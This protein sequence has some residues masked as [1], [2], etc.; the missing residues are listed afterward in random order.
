MVQVRKGEVLEPVRRA[1]SAVLIIFI[2]GAFFIIAA[3]LLT[4]GNLVGRLEAKGQ[5]LRI[6]DK[7][8]RR[9]SYLASS[10][11]LA[12]GF[13][14][15]IR[16]ILSNIQV[17]VQWLVSRNAADK[18]PELKEPLYQIAGEVARGHVLFEKFVAFV[19]PTESVVS[20]VNIGE[21][22]DELLV[23]LK[24]ELDR[25]NIKVIREYQEP[26]PALRSDRGKLRQVMQN[27]LLNAVERF[28]PGRRNPA[29]REERGRPHRG[30]GARQRAGD[31][32]RTNRR[33][34]LSRSL[35]PS[36]QGTGLGLPICRSI[37]GQLGGEIVLESQPGQGA[38]F[39][40]RLPLRINGQG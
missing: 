9:T 12:M 22:L 11:E 40:V 35:P 32:T 30:G 18:E 20:E 38:A 4:T 25:Y 6:L 39:T 2:A 13:F 15:E 27:L 16:D 10:M 17:S 29:G 34:C 14:D 24:R 26:M 37:L 31:W 23:F 3:I 36:R 8:L 19:R 7:Q 28:G 33:R 1:R 5:H 21:L